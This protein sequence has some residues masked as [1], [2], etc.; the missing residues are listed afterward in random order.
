MS[1]T[2]NNV[3][4]FVEKAKW[5][6]NLLGLC[7]S[8]K[9]GELVLVKFADGTIGYGDART[10]KNY[11][12]SVRVKVPVQV[13]GKGIENRDCAIKFYAVVTDAQHA[14]C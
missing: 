9:P 7:P 12:W 14:D 11:N 4:Q 10:P 13:L 3:D 5:K 1:I 8:I 2:C 6:R